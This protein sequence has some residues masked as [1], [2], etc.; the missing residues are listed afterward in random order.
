MATFD[1][2]WEAL[3]DD[4]HGGALVNA[5]AATPYDE[6]D[7]RVSA[8]PVCSLVEAALMYRCS[9]PVFNI[10][11]FRTGDTALMKRAWYAMVHFRAPK[12]LCVFV[13]HTYRDKGLETV[14]ERVL[15]IMMCMREEPRIWFWKEMVFPQFQFLQD[16]TAL[17]ECFAQCA[18]AMPA[19]VA[20]YIR[21]IL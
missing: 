5:M 16:R 7:K 14:E 17:R 13:T 8:R 10:I 9:A 4:G 21:T 2:I 1:E 15:W 12:K 3:R 20:A 6:Y 18:Q 19:S 11:C